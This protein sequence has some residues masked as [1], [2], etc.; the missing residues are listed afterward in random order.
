MFRIGDKVVYMGYYT[1]EVKEIKDYGYEK[2][3]RVLI[4]NHPA[5]DEEIWLNV[6]E[7]DKD[8]KVYDRIK[9]E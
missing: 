8:L 1:G 5:I 6:R 4:I 3:V 7:N 2:E 9:E